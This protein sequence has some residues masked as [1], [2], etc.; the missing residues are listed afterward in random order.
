M[1]TL[2]ETAGYLAVLD[3]AVEAWRHETYDQ[4]DYDL[5]LC[6]T[7]EQAGICPSCDGFHP[8][9]SAWAGTRCTVGTGIQW[10]HWRPE[11]ELQ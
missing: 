4:Y 5:H 9:Q 2:T 10:Y 7:L 6:W 11:E 3:E 8:D 1:T